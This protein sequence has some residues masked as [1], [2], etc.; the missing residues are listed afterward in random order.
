MITG[1][2][3]LWRPPKFVYGLSSAAKSNRFWQNLQRAAIFTK[4]F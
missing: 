3:D 1:N 2:I 4:I